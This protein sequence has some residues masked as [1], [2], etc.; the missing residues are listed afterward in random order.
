MRIGVIF[1]YMKL[2]TTLVCLITLSDM[3]MYVIV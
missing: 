3:D 2:I 1:F